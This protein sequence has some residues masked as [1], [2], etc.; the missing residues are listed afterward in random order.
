MD[1]YFFG[2]GALAHRGY[3]C[4]DGY[5]SMVYDHDQTSGQRLLNDSRFLYALEKVREISPLL[6][7]YP[8]GKSALLGDPNRFF[9]A[10]DVHYQLAR[11]ATVGISRKT[12]LIVGKAISRAVRNAFLNIEDNCNRAILR[13]FVDQVGTT[14]RFI[15][16]NWAN[17]MEREIFPRVDLLQGF[18]LGYLAE[19]K[20]LGCLMKPHG[21]VG[22]FAFDPPGTVKFPKWEENEKSRGVVS[23]GPAYHFGSSISTSAD[24]ESP[25]EI[26]WYKNQE[27]EACREDHTPYIV[28]PTT[29]KNEYLIDQR[30]S[31]SH[32]LNL[33]RQTIGEQGRFFF[34][35]YAFRDEDIHIRTAIRAGIRKAADTSHMTPEVEDRYIKNPGIFLVSPRVDPPLLRRAEETVSPLQLGLIDAKFEQWVADGCSSPLKK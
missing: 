7:G 24:T 25:A 1:T 13:R 12:P 32:M 17:S 35:G 16:L 9:T 2:T 10:L 34:I 14:C 4:N 6:A 15:D 33:V 18:T 31:F 28:S 23:G 29:F 27:P 21:S 30:P 22:S 3:P 8:T 5:L 26:F 20:D 19:R 11:D